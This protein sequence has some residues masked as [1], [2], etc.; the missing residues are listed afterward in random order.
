MLYYIY[1]KLSRARKGKTQTRFVALIPLGRMEADRTR[2]E[3][4]WLLDRGST[5][6]KGP[7]AG[8]DLFSPCCAGK[9]SGRIR[10][11]A[12]EFV[13]VRFAFP[14]SEAR[15]DGWGR[16]LELQSNHARLITRTRLE[17]GDRL[18]LSFELP[19][20]AF[21]GIRTEVHGSKTDEDGY[22]VCDLLFPEEKDRVSLGRALQRIL[23]SG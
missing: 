4:R 11:S 16:F 20:E 9:G 14:E 3:R 23:A 8:A 7:R 19:G 12:A 18:A 1:V 17:K 13:P 21:A 6:T 15:H 5:S 10:V 22:Y 2:L